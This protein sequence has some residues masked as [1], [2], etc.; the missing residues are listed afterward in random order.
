M[1]TTELTR[2][3][4]LDRPVQFRISQDEYQALKE[5][6]WSSDTHVATFVTHA[7]RAAIKAH[8]AS[9]QATAS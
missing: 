3:K 9:H 2:P 7:V 4:A 6:A 1:A 5:I 8:Q